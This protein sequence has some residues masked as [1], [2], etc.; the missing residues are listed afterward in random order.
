MIDVDHVVGIS[1]AWRAGRDSGNEDPALEIRA[2]KPLQFNS[3]GWDEQRETQGVRQNSRRDQQGASDQDQQAID[4][5]IGRHL[6]LG[7]LTLDSTE[8]ANPGPSS[9]PGADNAGDDN[10]SDG[11]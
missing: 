2:E 8:T 5:G 1:G 10:Q 11:E 3:N 4:Q 6:S 7:Q 9:R